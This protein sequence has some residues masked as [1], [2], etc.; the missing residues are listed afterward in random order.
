MKVMPWHN[1]ENTPQT[2]RKTYIFL[3]C[4][5]FSFIS[6][7]FIK[8]SRESSAIIPVTIELVNIPQELIITGQSDSTF[9][10]NVQS[11]GVK[12]LS[13]SFLRRVSKIESDFNALQQIRRDGN[14]VFFLTSA[15]AETR[16]SVLSD[17]PRTALTVHPDTIF[18][19]TV[20]AFS[21]K[22]PVKL[23]KD[24]DL[25]TGFKVYDI[26]ALT[27]DSIIV[28]RPNRDG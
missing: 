15:Q 28:T 16:F 11:T 18:F 5:A 22:V 10:V 21:K 24:L 7:L 8:L 14:P 12:L 1:I 27:P 13:S 26:P 17:I 4:L 6:W 20:S 19:N 3:L 25:Q 2:R 23:V 9:V